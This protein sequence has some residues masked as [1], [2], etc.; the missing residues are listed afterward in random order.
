MDCSLTIPVELLEMMTTGMLTCSLFIHFALFL[1]ILYMCFIMFWPSLAVPALVSRAPVSELANDGTR[2]RAAWAVEW[3]S[4]G[5]SEAFVDCRHRLTHV[6]LCCRLI[7]F[8]LLGTM[9]D[10]WYDH[11]STLQHSFCIVCVHFVLSVSLC[12]DKTCM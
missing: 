11:L 8:Y 9:T 5:S 12:S 10:D 2:P 3:F 7:S 1:F 6:N 4:Q